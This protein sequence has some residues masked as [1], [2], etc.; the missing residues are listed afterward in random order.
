LYVFH[1]KIKTISIGNLSTGG[2]GK[3]PHIE[4]LVRLLSQNYKVATLSRGYGRKTNGFKIATLTD[5]ARTI[6]DEPTQYYQKFIDI[7]VAVDA[8]RRRGIKKLTAQFPQL[9]VILMDDAFQHRSVKVGMQIVLSDYANMY[10]NDRMLPTGNLREFKKGIQRADVIIVSKTPAIFSPIER[11]HLLAKINPL[12]HQKVFFSFIKYHSFTHFFK[13]TIYLEQDFKQVFAKDTEVLVFAGIANPSLLEDFVRSTSKAY[14]LIRFDDHHA[15]TQAD[16]AK[17]KSEF[18]DLRG[19]KKI[20]L[21]T[22]KDAMRLL[23]LNLSSEW[24][25]LPLFFVSIAVQMH[26]QDEENFN[27][28]IINYVSTN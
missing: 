18:E 1:P 10:Y 3:T 19:T 26:Q 13:K 20:I 15:F 7:I 4:Y 16:L 17:I 24:S 9:Q 25:S 22:E 12:P 5:N 6:G 23:D 28:L 8:N 21:T 14:K 11:R 2:T 27:Q